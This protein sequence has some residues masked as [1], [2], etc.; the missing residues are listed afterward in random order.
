VR[1]GLAAPRAAANGGESDAPD[2]PTPDWPTP[3][4]A[5]PRLLPCDEISLGLAPVVIRDI[6]AA[7]CPA[8]CHGDRRAGHGVGARGIRADRSEAG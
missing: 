7:P 1:F 2:W 8:A 5:N 3:E 6:D 4:L